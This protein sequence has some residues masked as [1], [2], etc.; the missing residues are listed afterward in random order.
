MEKVT[1]R[2][3]AIRVTRVFRVLR[4]FSLGVFAFVCEGFGR[5][6]RQGSRLCWWSSGRSSFERCGGFRMVWVV[7]KLKGVWFWAT[8]NLVGWMI[9]RACAD[10]NE[11]TF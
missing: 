11:K 2:S 10:R 9:F 1:R 8:T 7:L 3:F 5:D 6:V 4:L